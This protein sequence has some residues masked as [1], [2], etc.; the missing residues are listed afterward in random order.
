M[1]M[2]S[3]TILLKKRL[4][5][6]GLLLC[7]TACS[8]SVQSE[9]LFGAWELYHYGDAAS[10]VELLDFAHDQVVINDR[11]GRYRS[12]S[13]ETVGNQIVLRDTLWQEPLILDIQSRSP[14]PSI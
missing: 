3:Y 14:N 10:V 7:F 1:T 2:L 11:Y 12:V 5:V 4:S 9:D 13:R 8:H 6:V